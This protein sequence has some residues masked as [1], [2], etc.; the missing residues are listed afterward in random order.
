VLAP[1]KLALN[2]L[3]NCCQISASTSLLAH[4]LLAFFLRVLAR[5]LLGVDITSLKLHYHSP[6]TNTSKFL[7]LILATQSHQIP[8]PKIQNKRLITMQARIALAAFMNFPRYLE[9]YSVFQEL[10]DIEVVVAG[11]DLACWDGPLSC[12]HPKF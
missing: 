3:L 12:F 2:R 5:N 10:K 8:H 1:Y 6:Y 4:S 11:K 9:I 7:S